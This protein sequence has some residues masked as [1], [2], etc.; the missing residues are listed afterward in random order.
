MLTTTHGPALAFRMSQKP[1]FG[2]NTVESAP[3]SAK[4]GAGVA[5]T[6]TTWCCGGTDPHDMV[7]WW[8]S[9]VVIR[10]CRK[11]AKKSVK[12]GRKVS[13]AGQK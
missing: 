13:K 9:A 5:Q 6:H 7:L 10:A 2:H 3:V 11:R 12:S 8:H 1:R 4:Y